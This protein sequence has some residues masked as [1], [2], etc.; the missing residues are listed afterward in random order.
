M[1][2]LGKCGSLGSIGR[3]TGSDIVISACEVFSPK[4]GQRIRVE[5]DF[6]TTISSGKFLLFS[7]QLIS[8]SENCLALLNEEDQES[9]R[10]DHD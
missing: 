4:S 7:G 10:I 6:V 5:R 8:D 1:L 3:Q 9:Q 2:G